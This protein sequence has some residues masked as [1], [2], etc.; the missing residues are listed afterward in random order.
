M[1]SNLGPLL[2]AVLVDGIDPLGIEAGR[3]PD[4]SVN[5]VPL[6]Q[7]KF[8]QI[9]TILS[10]DAGDQSAFRDHFYNSSLTLR[11]VQFDK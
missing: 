9:G 1:E 2:M 4:D 10:G 5:L 6:G 8:S 7:K 11:V 3:A